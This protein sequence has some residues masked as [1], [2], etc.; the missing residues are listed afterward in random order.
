M[1]ARILR[2][3]QVPSSPPDKHPLSPA[4][5]F[6]SDVVGRPT[7]KRRLSVDYSSLSEADDDDDEE[8]RPLAARVTRQPVEKKKENGRPAAGQRGGKQKHSMKSKAH[9][10][11]ANIPPPTAAERE[12]MRPVNGVNGYDAKVKVEDKMDEGQL[13]RLATGVTVDAAGPASAAVRHLFAKA[14][15]MVLR[16]SHV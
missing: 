5:S 1:R 11:P 3:P 15:R 13:S 8:E 14:S 16:F 9:T 7:K 2:P 12:E 6:L 4:S 10:A